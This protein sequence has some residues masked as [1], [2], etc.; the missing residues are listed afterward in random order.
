V[1]PWAGA[2]VALAFA[3]LV[4]SA[5]ASPGASTRSQAPPKLMGKWVGN[6]V[7]SR[8]EL[9]IASGGP[10]DP[11][12]ATYAQ[13]WVCD[14]GGPRPAAAGEQGRTQAWGANWVDDRTLRGN[15]H[16]CY[17]GPAGPGGQPPGPFWT[18]APMDATVS[19]DGNT[20]TY[21]YNWTAYPAGSGSGT[22]TRMLE[23]ADVVTEIRGPKSLEVGGKDAFTVVVRNRV[24]RPRRSP[25]R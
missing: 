23:G 12:V 21:S 5:T 17:T 18:F 10:G 25:G 2:V 8:D 7:G 20:I 15:F 24:S 9:T 1:K 4:P 22:F 3:L 14:K 13:S 19:A 11:V 6:G 16:F